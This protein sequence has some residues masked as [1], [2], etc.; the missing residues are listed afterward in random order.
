MDRFRAGSTNN[1]FVRGLLLIDEP[2]PLLRYIVNATITVSVFGSDSVVLAGADEV[3]VPYVR[4]VG[5]YA[6]YR[7]ILP[8]TVPFV[9]GQVY[10]RRVTAISATNTLVVTDKVPAIASKS[11]RL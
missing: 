11:G 9:A 4:G 5:E 2:D 1:V 10:V 8:K 6:L 7:A 3:A